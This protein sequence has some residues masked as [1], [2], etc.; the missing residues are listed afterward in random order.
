M[1]RAFT[2]DF[3]DQIANLEHEA[4]VRQ[5]VLGGAR[6]SAR[7]RRAMCSTAAR[8]EEYER[9]GIAPTPDRGERR[10][11]DVAW[12]ESTRPARPAAPADTA[13]SARGR[14]VGAH[15]IAVHDHL[16]D[17]L[18]Q[19]R[20]LL[21]SVAGGDISP[22]AARTAIDTMTIRQNNWTLGA[23]C[24]A[25]CRLV[26]THHG[27]E[28]AAVFP[29]L[30]SCDKG[31]EPVV[32]RLVAEHEVIHEVLER[33]DRALVGLVGAAGDFSEL[34]SAA[35]LLSDTLCSHLSY[36]ERELVEPLARY[37]FYEG[38]L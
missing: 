27:I 38:Q 13:Y 37:G 33:L 22:D 15:L 34:Q 29:Y 16:R 11:R 1:R 4:G 5:Y 26:A 31:L 19:I 23:Y 25:Y 32:D 3:Q 28:D 20:D 21:D 17:E 18:A 36:E 30:R 6:P 24:A 14:L 2:G 35:D 7:Y 9:L 10:S 12:D 8:D